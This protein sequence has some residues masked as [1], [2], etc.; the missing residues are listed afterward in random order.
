MAAAPEDT[1]VR[2]TPA[3]ETAEETA[4]AEEMC[5][6]ERHVVVLRTAATARGRAMIQRAVDAQGMPVASIQGAAAS[7]SE[8]PSEA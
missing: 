6:R 7:E 8:A 3:P 5:E 4:Q 1:E 2:E